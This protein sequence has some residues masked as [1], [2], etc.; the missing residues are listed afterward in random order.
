L[1]TEIDIVMNQPIDSAAHHD[2]A[3]LL[4]PWYVNGR[5]EESQRLSVEAHLHACTACQEEVRTQQKICAAMSASNPE[6]EQLPTASLRALLQKID[7]TQ[8]PTTIQ[9]PVL[10]ERA[11]SMSWQWSGRV[12]ASLAAIAV[13]VAG[14]LTFNRLQTTH[15]QPADYYTVTSPAPLVPY[16]VIRAVF[17]PALTVTEMQSILN[18]AQLTIVAGPTAAG[19]YSLAKTGTQPVDASLQRLRGHKEVLFAEPTAMT[20]SISSV[21]PP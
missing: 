16:E 21:S 12:A 4:I 13:A 8:N 10:I 6:V 19:V 11:R 17:A 1:N 5:L 9:L 18:D 3:W 15:Q 14:W 2:S 7:S 20:A